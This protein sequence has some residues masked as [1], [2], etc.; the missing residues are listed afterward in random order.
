[1]LEK[2]QAPL[3]IETPAGNSRQTTHQVPFSLPITGIENIIQTQETGSLEIADSTHGITFS[4][5]GGD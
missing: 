4:P 3:L 2:T 5:S 1:L